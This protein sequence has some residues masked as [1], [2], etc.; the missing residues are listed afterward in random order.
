MP[1][2]KQGEKVRMEHPQESIDE[3]YLGK[4]GTFRS[5]YS[6]GQC[7]VE[8]PGGNGA[9]LVS[10]E[11]LRRVLPDEEE[12]EEVRTGRAEILPYG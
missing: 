6:A 9:S 11:A 7:V 3:G 2:F 5:V 10:I 12:P 8:F 4:K 1:P